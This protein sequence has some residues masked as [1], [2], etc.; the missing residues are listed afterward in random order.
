MCVMKP[1]LFLAA[2]AAVALAAAPALTQDAPPA[3]P[4]DSGTP[5][6][7]LSFANDPYRLPDDTKFQR[8]CFNGRN[9]VGVN[10]ADRTLY[11]Q[12]RTGGIY[13]MELAEG[14]E[15]LAAAQEL[16]VNPRRPVCT[17]ERAVVVSLKTPAGPKTCRANDVRRLT[18]T[19]VATLAASAQR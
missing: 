18:R 4:A 11:V 17:G 3:P 1:V 5:P 9:L 10:R 14:C 13:R 8:Q 12:A 2:A 15:A 7:F 6:N 16:T 19:E